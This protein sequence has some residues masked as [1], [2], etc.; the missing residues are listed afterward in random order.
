MSVTHPDDVILQRNRYRIEL[1]SVRLEVTSL[2]NANDRLESEKVD[3]LTHIK[4]LQKQIAS[5]GGQ[6]R[7]VRL[8]VSSSL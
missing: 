7:E 2:R 8:R 5:T 1:A 6:Q 4:D 3:L